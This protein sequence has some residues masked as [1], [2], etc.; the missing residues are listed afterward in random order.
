MKLFYTPNSPYARIARVAA[1]ELYLGERI[2]M[3]KVTVREA[4]SELLDYFYLTY[5]LCIGR[6]GTSAFNHSRKFWLIS[7][8]EISAIKLV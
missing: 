5:V 8:G 2:E 3:R 6:M 7:V 4:N 1:L